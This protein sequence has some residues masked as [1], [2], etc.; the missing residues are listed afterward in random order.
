M[1]KEFKI[2][3]YKRICEKCGKTIKSRIYNIFTDNAEFG[4]LKTKYVSCEFCGRQQKA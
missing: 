4:E 1:D 2:S 3:K